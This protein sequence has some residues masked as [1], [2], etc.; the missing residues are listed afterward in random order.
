MC[1]GIEEKEV[2][3]IKNGIRITDNFYIGSRLYVPTSLY[4]LYK[5][6]AFSDTFRFAELR[7][8]GRVFILMH[9]IDLTGHILMKWYLQP[10]HAKY[11]GVN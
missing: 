10:I 3:Q 4:L 1:R 9:L 7:H 6:G 2:N 11:I 8:I 5:K